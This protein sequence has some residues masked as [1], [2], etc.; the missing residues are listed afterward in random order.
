MFKYMFL[1]DYLVKRG[2]LA[3]GVFAGFILNLLGGVLP[4]IGDL[5]AG[6]WLAT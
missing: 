4:I 3:L 5:I 6:L 2:S 1:V